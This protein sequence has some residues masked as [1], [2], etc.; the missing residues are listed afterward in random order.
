MFGKCSTFDEILIAGRR[1]SLKCSQVVV[2]KHVQW[3]KMN[4]LGEH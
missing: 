1:Q 2:F 3:H 4:S